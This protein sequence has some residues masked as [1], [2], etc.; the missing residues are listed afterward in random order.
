[1][2]IQPLEIPPPH[3]ESFVTGQVLVHPFI[4]KR[5]PDSP[6]GL[7][8]PE[9]LQLPDGLRLPKVEPHPDWELWFVAMLPSSLGLYDP[10]KQLNDSKTFKDMQ[11]PYIEFANL[12]PENPQ[13]LLEYANTHGI[14]PSQVYDGQVPKGN[15]IPSPYSIKKFRQE[16]NKMRLFLEVKAIVAGDQSLKETPKF[17]AILSDL[18]ALVID[19]VTE[20]PHGKK[21]KETINKISK[22]EE[23][24]A[25]LFSLINRELKGVS[26]RINARPGQKHIFER[27]FQSSCLLQALYATLAEDIASPI[28]KCADPKC[29]EFFLAHHQ[30]KMY[31]S[32]K[33]G[34]RVANRNS[35]RRKKEA[36]RESQASGTSHKKREE[37]K[38]GKKRW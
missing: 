12:D 15:L 18:K 9:E 28:Q 35:Y 4:L 14:P 5:L 13:K 34:V 20:K 17:D 11:P 23:L 30:G 26:M 32:P 1:M 8:I 29:G 6:R 3:G 21:V 16:I 19:R 7:L 36:K 38:H 37:I 33:C 2:S 10:M 22:R 25:M 27:T 31:C 24:A